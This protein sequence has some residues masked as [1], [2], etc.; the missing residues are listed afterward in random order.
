MNKGFKSDNPQNSSESY[1]I[2]APAENTSMLIRLRE[3]SDWA[4]PDVCL[5]DVAVAGYARVAR[6]LKPFHQQ[7]SMVFPH[8]IEIWIFRKIYQAT[9]VFLYI[10]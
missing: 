9:G 3:T 7:I 8:I 6:L 4:I 10:V 1:A 5:P 2:G